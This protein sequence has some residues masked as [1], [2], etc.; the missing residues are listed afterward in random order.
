VSHRRKIP[1]KTHIIPIIIGDPELS[2]LLFDE[3]GIYVQ[4]Y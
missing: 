4:K 1:T 3:Y 2:K